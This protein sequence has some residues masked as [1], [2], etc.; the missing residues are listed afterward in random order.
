M[1]YNSL[2]AKVNKQSSRKSLVKAETKRPIKQV[3]AKGTKMEELVKEELLRNE[4]PS[5]AEQRRISEGLRA[6]LD[7]NAIEMLGE[8][9]KPHEFL[10]RVARGEPIASRKMA[11]KYD[12]DGYEIGREWVPAIVYPS[13][14]ERID[15]AKAAAPF[16]APRLAVQ[17]INQEGKEVDVFTKV[18]N[19]LAGK[20]PV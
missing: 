3:P 9:D 11:V 18:M 12:D 17:I 2:M 14:K 20:L 6:G 7:A 19:K 13:L 16:L 10:A 4:L 5:A 1:L 8:G 15:C